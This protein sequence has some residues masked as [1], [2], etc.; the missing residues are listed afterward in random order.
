LVEEFDLAAG[1]RMR[2]HTHVGPGVVVGLTGAWI[3]EVGRREHACGPGDVVILPGEAAH[4]ERC[5]SSGARC[6]LFTVADP[7]GLEPRTRRLLDR[8]RRI[9][10]AAGRGPR[11]ARELARSDALATD[12]VEGLVLDLFCA[13]DLDPVEAPAELR[14][15]ARLREAIDD[16]F[17]RP[18]DVGALA[19][20]AGRSREHVHRSFRRAYGVLPAAYVRAR[21]LDHAARLL[22]ERDLSVAAIAAESGFTDQSHLTRLFRARFGVT[23]A[24]YR[25]LHG[26]LDG[27]PD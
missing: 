2:R 7:D 17:L 25:A 24:R 15:L 23:P 21:R 18:A 27:D 13:L 9:S 3:A 22:V 26:A 19:A 12:L 20:G 10:G 6:L 8:D 1:Y 5:G 14:W 4:R 16:G 11:I